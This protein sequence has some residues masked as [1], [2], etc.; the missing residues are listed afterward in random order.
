M[1]I[2][3]IFVL[4]GVLLFTSLF[5]SVAQQFAGSEWQVLFNG[6]NLNGWHLLNGQH[7]VAVK[8]GM[9]VGTCIAGLPNG[10]LATEEEFGDFILELEV[11]TDLL[12]HNSGIQFRSRSYEG[13]RNGR[14]HG[15]QAEI[16]VTP[17]RWSGGIYDEARRGWLYILE[18]E[19]PAKNAYKNN[20]W[21]HYRIEAI[22]NSNRIWVNGIPTA[23]LVDDESMRGFIALQLHGNSRPQMPKTNHNVYFRNIRIKTDSIE[24]SPYDDIFVMNLIPNHLS[25][26]EEYQGFSLL[27]NG[28]NLDGWR[29]VD[30]PEIPDQG[31]QIEEGVLTIDSG[32]K[33]GLILTENQYGPFELKFDFMQ[34][35]EQGKAGIS[36]LVSDL[37][38]DSRPGTSGT[39][40]QLTARQ[41]EGAGEWNKG[42]IRV[43]PSG[44][45]QYWLNGYE[46][47]EYH[48]DSEKPLKGNIRLDATG[49]PISYRSIK[50]RRLP[51]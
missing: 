45:V 11:K 22:G 23:H 12:L 37:G 50:L 14:V 35:E 49:S 10:F 46:I 1:K 47:L 5:N 13:Y 7:E 31:W 33:D 3:N 40:G 36:Y 29:G 24:P 42:I 25:G 21:N 43:L 2:L 44:V 38:E 18:D 20:Q 16:D 51:D 4:T 32:E 34:H 41:T 28:I 19:T 17:Q 9:I 30:R 6:E 8:D 27:W 26:Q 39:Y 48:L 15:Y